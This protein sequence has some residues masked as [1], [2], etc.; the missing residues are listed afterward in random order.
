[1]GVGRA[2]WLRD[3]SGLAF[4]ALDERGLLGVYSQ[5]FTPGRDSTAS[6]RAL[7]GF[8][9]DARTESFALAPAGDRVAISIERVQSFLQVATNLP[10]VEPPR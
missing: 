1:M 2:R 5:D 4:V 7:G 3:G 10:G 6:R 9:A 8:D